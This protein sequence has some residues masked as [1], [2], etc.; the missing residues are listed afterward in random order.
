MANKRIGQFNTV[1]PANPDVFLIEQGGVTSNTTLSSVLVAAKDYTVSKIVDNFSTLGGNIAA[2]SFS[3]QARI[4][5]ISVITKDNK[6]KIWGYLGAYTDKETVVGGFLIRPYAMYDYSN[7]NTGGYSVPFKDMPYETSLLLRFID[8]NGEDYITNNSVTVS[9]V[10][11]TQ[12]GSLALLS[13]GTVWV[14]GYFLYSGISSPTTGYTN[15]FRKIDWFVSNSVTIKDIS[16]NY[17]PTTHRCTYCAVGT[18]SN[19]YIWGHNGTGQLGQGNTT[20]SQI[21]IKVTT[22]GVVDNVKQAFVAGG[23]NATTVVVTNDG[24]LWGCGYNGYGQLGQGNTTTTSS[25]VKAQV[26]G[27]TFL[28][29]VSEAVYSVWGVRSNISIIKT[30][31]TLWTSG[32][33]SFRQLADGTTTDSKYFKQIS[34][35][36]NVTKVKVVGYVDAGITNVVLTSNGNVYTWGYNTYG[37]CGNGTTTTVTTP[38]LVNTGGATNIYGSFSSAGYNGVGYLKNKKLY[39]A[40]GVVYTSPDL[41]STQSSFYP[42]HISN[43]KDVTFCN[44]DYDYSSGTYAANNL[45]GIFVLT[46]SGEIWAW[47]TAN[48]NALGAL[49]V[50][51]YTPVKLSIQ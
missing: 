13:D 29:Q 12:G 40:G 15:S 3:G 19:V 37:Q 24:S 36:S 33:N 26:S 25:F 6:V 50:N 9:K 34:G 32:D 5:S 44:G 39:L 49:N 43:V 41:T 14:A 16:V 7:I 18:N 20:S 1:V 10:V 47:G 46:E 8:T 35:L 45:T 22:V 38:A 28:T 17:A 4:P 2:F 11:K 48:H 27:G 51:T 30:D 23:E 42:A 21:P 31:G